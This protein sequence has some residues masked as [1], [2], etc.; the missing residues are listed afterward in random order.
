ME[1]A[2]STSPTKASGQPRRENHV[3][4]GESGAVIDSKHLG[5][6]FT[7][8]RVGEKYLREVD[9]LVRHGFKYD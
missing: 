3:A 8:V 5:P 9:T 4:V 2:K 7:N 1:P 6:T